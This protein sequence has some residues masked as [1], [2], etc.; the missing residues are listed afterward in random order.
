MTATSPAD[1]VNRALAEI[2]SRTLVTDLES[3]DSPAAANA[4]LFYTPLRQ[5][6][7]RAAPWG[8]ARKTLALTTLGMLTD[9]PPG[10]PYPFLMKY[11]H[12]ADCLK[13][14]YILPPPVTP[15]AGAETVDPPVSDVGLL[16]F[17]WCAPSRA[18][19]YMIAYE[20]SP[21]ARRVILSNVDRALGVYTADVTDPG[22]FDPLFANALSMLLANKL[23]IP[24]S[25]NVNM[26]ASY[27]Q[28]ADRAVIE[29]RAA[30]GNEAIPST[31]HNVDWITARN[32][33]AGQGGFNGTVFG[34]PAWGSW[35]SGYDQQNWG[36]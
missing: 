32:V 13:M 27:L 19:R 5:Q 20:S 30:D 24:L 11:E 25:G 22:L 17:P 29:A 23:V 2:G 9:V 10:S 4:R 28:Q 21:D 7:L 26:K 3:E 35:Y 14:R 34:G 16:W 18:W 12:P 33:G 36:M 31:D 15:T 8:F 6:L 1:I